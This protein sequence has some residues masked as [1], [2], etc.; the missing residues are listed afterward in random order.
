[1]DGHQVALRL[2]EAPEM[3]GVVLVAMT[4]F[5]QDSDRELSRKAGFDH[6]MAS[7]WRPR[8]CPSF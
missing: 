6:H 8:C 5:G 2:R 1:M 3:A 4:G 7:Q